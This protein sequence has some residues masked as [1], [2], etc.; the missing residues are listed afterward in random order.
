MKTRACLRSL[1]DSMSFISSSSDLPKEACPGFTHRSG[2]I[3]SVIAV[4]SISNQAT[5]CL[6]TLLEP[7]A[8]GAPAE[9]MVKWF[10]FGIELLE[11][12]CGDC[13]EATMG[14]WMNASC[15]IEIIHVHFLECRSW[16]SGP[17]SIFEAAANSFYHNVKSIRCFLYLSKTMRVMMIVVD[18][19]HFEG[20]ATFGRIEGSALTQ[21]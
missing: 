12:F 16:L 6:Y 13:G 15:C 9:G 1:Y 18:V 3:S 5:C 8:C 11:A 17:T 20:S 14:G 10:E 7:F 2:I 21:P 19:D 4:P